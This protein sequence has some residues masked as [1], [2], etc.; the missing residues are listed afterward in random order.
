MRRDIELVDCRD[1]SRRAVPRRRRNLT[2]L[3]AR[4]LSLQARGADF[5]HHA[6]PSPTNSNGAL[7]PSVV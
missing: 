3:V 2:N 4:T 6:S 7:W 1:A 5:L